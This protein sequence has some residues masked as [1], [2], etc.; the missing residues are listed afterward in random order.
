MTKYVIVTAVSSHR[1]RYC[2]PVDELKKL[3][4]EVDPTASDLNEWARDCVTMQEVKEFSQE[5]LGET[6]ID[7]AIV[8]EDQMLD[9]FDND[10]KYMTSWSRQYKIDW[11]NKWKENYDYK[12]TNDPIIDDEVQIRHEQV[13]KDS[14]RNDQ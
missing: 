3:N 1:M 11:V 14:V 10:N 6:I 2:V 5:W 8:D 7:S 4:Q 13:V 12:K 9:Q